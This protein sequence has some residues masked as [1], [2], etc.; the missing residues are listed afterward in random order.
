MSDLVG[1]PEDWYS[2]V[3]AHFMECGSLVMLVLDS[4]LTG[5]GLKPYLHWVMFD[6]FILQITSTFYYPGKLWLHP[7]TIEKLMTGRLSKQTN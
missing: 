2:Y 6:T 7:N 1:N 4:E 3:A 5:A